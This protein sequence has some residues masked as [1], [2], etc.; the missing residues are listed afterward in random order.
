MRHK[1]ATGGDP[2]ANRQARQG[3]MTFTELVEEFS[4][5]HLA[6]QR[7]G[8]EARRYLVRYAVPVFGRLKASAV[9]RAD[10][11]RLHETHAERA[12]VAANR[13]VSA[14]GRA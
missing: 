4:E 2:L 6:K 13:L 9:K 3:E 5:R 1:V 10:I 8:G 7:A 11:I 12:P 14:I